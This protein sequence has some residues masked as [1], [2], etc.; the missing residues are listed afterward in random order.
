MQSGGNT[1][2]WTETIYWSGFCKLWNF[3][4]IVSTW[5]NSK[6]IVAV[7][8]QGFWYWTTIIF[9]GWRLWTKRHTIFVMTDTG[10]RSTEA[11]LGSRKIAEFII[12]N[13]AHNW[14]LRLEAPSSLSSSDKYYKNPTTQLLRQHKL[15]FEERP[16]KR[17]KIIGI[18]ENMIELLE[19]TVKKLYFKTP[20]CFSEHLICR[21][22]FV[23]SFMSSATFSKSF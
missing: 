8:H 12:K 4:T 15:V 3:L 7:Y 21:I 2:A 6:N 10:T 11:V 22:T 18:V 16:T 19:T 20:T 5:P 13:L 23:K 14:I 9:R 1:A 17:H